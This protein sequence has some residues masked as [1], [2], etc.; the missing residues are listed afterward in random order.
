MGIGVQIT[1][2]L[3]AAIAASLIMIMRN[4]A[5]IFGRALS[6]N[7]ALC[8]CWVAYSIFM[9]VVALYFGLKLPLG[10]PLATNA[11]ATAIAVCVSIEGILHLGRVRADWNAMVTRSLFGLLI[12]VG[13]VA[14]F[15]L[16][17]VNL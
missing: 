17:W 11:P 12:L 9:G 14:A 13:V 16:V 7:E 15:C 4:P 10:L 5:R 2:G 1:L 8:V 3:F 6:L